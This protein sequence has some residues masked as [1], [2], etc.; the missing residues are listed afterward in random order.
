VIVVLDTDIASLLLKQR[1]PTQLAARL[2]AEPV[3]I[4]FVTLAELT[5]W[6]ELRRWGTARRA[7]LQSG[8]PQ[9]ETFSSGTDGR[10]ER[11]NPSA[12]ERLLSFRSVPRWS[13]RGTWRV[14]EPLHLDFSAHCRSG[15]YGATS[16]LRALHVVVI[17]WR[18]WDRT[19]GL[20]RVKVVHSALT[21]T[22]EPASR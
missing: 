10:T 22:V 6:A 7:S 5:Q 15:K 17:G 2:D 1:L 20:F 19:S 3:C 8:R 12:L 14:R 16:G 9:H 21:A 13:H 11:S 18:S 4:T